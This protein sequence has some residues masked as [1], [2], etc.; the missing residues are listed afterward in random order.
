MSA[1]GRD[2][3]LLLDARNGVAEDEELE[4]GASSAQAHGFYKVE[5]GSNLAAEA[6]QEQLSAA[7]Q[8]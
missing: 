7:Q 6:F 5:G 2:Q 8:A 3:S 4:A 1:K